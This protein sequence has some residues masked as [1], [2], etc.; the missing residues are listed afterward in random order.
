MRPTLGVATTVEV[1]GEEL[2]RDFDEIALE[3]AEKALTEWGKPEG[4]LLYLKRA[5][6][7]AL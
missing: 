5:P 2:D 4:E 1:D 7:A 3:V 6:A